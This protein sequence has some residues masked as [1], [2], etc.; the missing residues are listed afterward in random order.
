[1]ATK[2]FHYRNHFFLFIDERKGFDQ[3]DFHK[4]PYHDTYEFIYVIKGKLQADIEG[5]RFIINP[6]QLLVIKPCEF[7]HITPDSS[8]DYQSVTVIFPSEDLPKDIREIIAPIN[9]FYDLS[10]TYASRK[11]ERMRIYQETI[12]PE[13]ERY[14]I[15]ISE[16]NVILVLVSALMNY[17]AELIYDDDLFLIT[18]YIDTHIVLVN[19]VDDVSENIG[20]SRSKI[21]KLIREKMHT[22]VMSY[23]RTKKMLMAKTLI[24]NGVPLNQVCQKCGYQNYSTFYRNYISVFHHSPKISDIKAD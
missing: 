14:N 8:Q 10:N 6:Q 7:H 23:I 19:S 18:N 9:H 17:K 13:K 22:S 4:I 24:G 20:M 15:L 3:E 1:M 2:R 11:F 12:A 5:Q 16:M 21:E